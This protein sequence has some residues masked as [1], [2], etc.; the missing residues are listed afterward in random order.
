MLPEQRAGLITSGITKYQRGI[1]IA[2]WFRP[3]TP[4]KEGY[5]CLILDVFS[6]TELLE[7]AIKDI[8]IPPQS[9]VLL[10]EVDIV[11]SATEIG[12][13]IS[14]NQHGTFD[15]I[16]SSH[17]FEH[18][19]NPIKFLQGC[20]KVLKSSGRLIMALPDQRACFDYFRPHT[21]IAEW[22]YAYLEEQKKPNKRQIFEFGAYFSEY[23]DNEERIYAFSLD[24]PRE[25]IVCTG[26]IVKEYKK[27]IEES[28]ADQYTD[29]HCSV[30]T[31]SSFELLIMECN[32]L[33]LTNFRIKE[34]SRTY[35]CEF[36]VVL[37][38]SEK[39]ADIC[40]SHLERSRLMHRILE[41][42]AKASAWGSHC[43]GGV[44]FHLKGLV[45]EVLKMVI[46]FLA[47]NH[48]KS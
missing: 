10:E 14:K 16:I 37:E 29:A 33:K 38:K 36:L 4:K 17:N 5:N 44:L 9:H 8:N 19:P 28:D 39:Q 3:L 20:E 46:P 48:K 42:K 27:W 11:G 1:E 13:L 32:L 6:K 30:M 2:P 22:L 15:Y 24:H 23:C 35:D 45:S 21:T 18:L 43:R 47:N 41:E 12:D 34:I 31:P 26:D 25:K 7:R 40:T